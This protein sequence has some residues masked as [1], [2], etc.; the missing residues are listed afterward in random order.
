MGVED[1][2]V[3]ESHKENWNKA[4]Y[5]PWATWDSESHKENWN[6]PPVDPLKL[7]KAYESHKE[8]WNY[9]EAGAVGATLGAN[10][11]KRIETTE[12]GEKTSEKLR[13][14]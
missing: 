12:A 2:V 7:T 3:Q 11:I 5:I 1:D 9:L 4:P 13:I 14:S 8:N 6:I 10:L